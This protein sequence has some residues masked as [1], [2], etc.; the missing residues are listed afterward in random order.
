LHN[1]GFLERTSSNWW[2]WHKIWPT[3][4]EWLA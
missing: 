2:E 3:C 4:K 1:S